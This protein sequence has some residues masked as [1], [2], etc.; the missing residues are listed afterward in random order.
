M[1]ELVEL[2]I[3]TEGPTE[4]NFVKKVLM[5][6]LLELGVRSEF[7]NVLTSREKGNRGGIV[8]YLK[9]RNDINRWLKERSGWKVKFSTMFDFYA[10]PKDFPGASE[11]KRLADPYLRVK[12][13]EDAFADDIGD[14]RFIPYIQLHEFEALLFSQPEAFELEFPDK[15]KEIEKLQKYLDD[16]GGNPEL[17]NDHPNRAPSKRII[18]L[19]PKYKKSKTSAGPNIADFI[20][21]EH[22]K[23]TCRHFREWLEK[24]EALNP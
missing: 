18:K 8:N 6:H 1:K 21:I 24:L 15:L 2:N 17:I 22:L 4:L 10:L 20:G 16:F 9:A 11:S 13:V 5:Y 7:R 12:T 3:T 19:I 23:A 14:S